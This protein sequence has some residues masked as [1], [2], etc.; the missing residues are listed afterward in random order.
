[1][2]QETSDDRSYRDRR[3][4]SFYARPKRANPADDEV[5][6]DTVLRCSVEFLDQLQVGEAVH[7][8]NDPR[9]FTVLLVFGF[10]ADQANKFLAQAQRSDDQMV[11]AVRL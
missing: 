1:M 2:F 6:F 3:R 9:L 4:E 5:D 10:A 7:L 11:V 8:E